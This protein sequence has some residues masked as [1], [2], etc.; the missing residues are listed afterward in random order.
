MP[1]SYAFQNILESGIPIDP[2]SYALYEKL[3]SAQ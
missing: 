2:V 1:L 3:V